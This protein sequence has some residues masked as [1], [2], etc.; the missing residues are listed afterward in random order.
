MMMDSN[1]LQ[2]QSVKRAL[3]FASRTTQSLY[4]AHPE[5]RRQEALQRTMAAN[6][7]IFHRVYVGSVH[8]EV[9]EAEV[10][11]LFSVFGPIKSVQMIVDQAVA[12]Q[13]K[14]KGYGFVDFE[15]PEAA[16]LA[17]RADGLEI[18]HR[19]I[20]IGRP[21][22]FPTDLPPGVP[23]PPANRIYFGNVHSGISEP[24][25]A[26]LLATV[27]PVKCCRLAP[28]SS[29]TRPAHRG[30]G[31]AEFERV[32]DAVTAVTL[33]NGFEIA[34]RKLAVSKAIV[35][36]PMIDGM[37][38]IVRKMQDNAMTVVIVMRDIVDKSEVLT[39]QQREELTSDCLAECM[40]FGSISDHQLIVDSNSVNFFVHYIEESSSASA[41]A[42]LNGRWFGGKRLTVQ[43]F[44]L[45]RYLMR[46]F[47]I[48]G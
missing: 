17:C 26:G 2:D 27:G 4:Q 48:P 40:K 3:E 46:D 25:L 44:D 47:T 22:N 23:R 7:S 21:A 20:K 36:G 10:A 29:A 8:F 14:H 16:E 34:G 24:E 38:S 43:G 39:E 32:A 37:E 11:R 31:Y 1:Y 5:L 12:H 18:A 9:S 6:L 15:V 42:A 30:F 45:D 13:P 19:P 33:L 35:G 41:I 28:D